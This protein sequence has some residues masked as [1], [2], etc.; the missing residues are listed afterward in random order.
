MWLFND[1]IMF[2]GLKIFFFILHND[3]FEWARDG[4]RKM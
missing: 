4:R 1:F 3:N 2:G